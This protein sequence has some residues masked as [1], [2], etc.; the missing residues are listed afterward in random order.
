MRYQLRVA[1]EDIVVAKLDKR[2]RY[3]IEAY[4]TIPKG[5]RFAYRPPEYTGDWKTDHPAYFQVIGGPG[6]SAYKKVSDDI[7]A[8]SEEVEA[9][10]IIEVMAMNGY[11]KA[12]ICEDLLQLLVNKGTITLAQFD[13][14]IQEYD[15]QLQSEG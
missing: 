8:N 3:G 7:E 15:Q 14:L 10:D 12:Y 2:K 1:T 6:D 4:G 11:N 5:Q 13:S 9:Q